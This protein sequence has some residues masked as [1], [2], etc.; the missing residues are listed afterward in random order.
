MFSENI[1]HIMTVLNSSQAKPTT[2]NYTKLRNGA[3][4]DRRGYIDNKFIT[5]LNLAYMINSI[6]Y[7]VKS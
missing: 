2:K 3:L 4:F 6:A 5:Q 1:K 7:A